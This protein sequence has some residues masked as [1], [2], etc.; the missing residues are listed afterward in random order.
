MRFGGVQHDQYEHA[1]QNDLHKQGKTDTVVIQPV[2]AET[3][4]RAKQ[5]AQNAGGCEG[6]EALTDHVADEF[7][8]LERAGDQLGQRNGGVDV[9]A[10][11]VAHRV[12]R[13]DETHAESERRDQI[14][15]AEPGVTAHRA[16]RTAA[17]EHENKGAEKFRNC[18][19]DQ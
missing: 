19:F 4:I 9:A 7:H 11:E 13:G 15:C 3:G 17:N 14:A 2:R 1:G 6:A 16:S 18:F 10:G 8:G 5:N 12:A